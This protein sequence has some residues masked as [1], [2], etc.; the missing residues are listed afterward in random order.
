MTILIVLLV[1]LYLCGFTAYAAQDENWKLAIFW[2]LLIT[3]AIMYGITVAYNRTA[4]RNGHA[5]IIIGLLLIALVG[6][7]LFEC[8]VHVIRW[9]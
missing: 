1:W 3:A 6:A 4:K 7:A 5:P 2:P 8:V 9:L